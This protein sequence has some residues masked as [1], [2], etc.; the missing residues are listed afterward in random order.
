MG[1]LKNLAALAAHEA[2]GRVAQRAESNSLQNQQGSSAQ[3]SAPVLY[4]HGEHEMPIYTY[5]P[6]PLRGTRKGSVFDIDVLPGR[7]VLSRMD[8][9]FL[10]AQSTPDMP[11][12]AYNGKPFGAI[13][14]RFSYFRELAEMGYSVQVKAKRLG[15]YDDKVTEMELMIPDTAEL[16]RW[17]N[18]CRFFGQVCYFEYAQTHLVSVTVNETDGDFSGLPD[19]VRG[20]MSFEYVPWKSKGTKTPMRI[21]VNCMGRRIFVASHG[22]PA[23]EVISRNMGNEVMACGMERKKSEYN[24]GY[25]WRVYILF[26]DKGGEND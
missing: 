21:A 13:S 20:G 15:M 3:S 23:Y 19:V 10:V 16:R 22:W 11:V 7:Q 12:V 26:S 18:A 8:D 25:Y 5:D 9:G 6:T 1:F 4:F 24:A 14:D 17:W 2:V